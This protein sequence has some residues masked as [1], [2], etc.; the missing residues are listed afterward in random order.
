MISDYINAAMR[1]AHYEFLSDDKLYYGEIPECNGVYATANNLEDCRD[2]LQ[3][4]LED[5]LLLSINKDLPIPVFDN[6]SL[7][8]KNVA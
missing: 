4:V 3:S 7:E 2:E 1:K 5:W 6:F 8:V